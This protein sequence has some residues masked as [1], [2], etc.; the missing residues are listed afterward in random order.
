MSH[1]LIC[2]WLGLPADGWPPDHYNLLGLERGEA[3]RDR[4][5]QHVHEHLE[6]VRRYQ[7]AHPEQV[8]EAMNRLAQAFV[9]LTDPDA[10][11]AYDATLGLAPTAP[12][13]GAAS[14]EPPAKPAAASLLFPSGAAAGE[15]VDPLAWL[16][17]PWNPAAA[18]PAAPAAGAPALV[19]WASAPPPPRL[20]PEP[21]TRGDPAAAGDGTATVRESTVETAVEHSPLPAEPSPPAEEAAPLGARRGLGTK[22]ALYY[23]ISR[24]R[25]LL[26][27]W[28]QAGRYLH[29]PT[30]L[31]TRPAE[32]TELIRLLQSVRRLLRTF[33]PL[34]GEAGQPG[35][36]VL[37]L[38]RQQLIVPTFQ[39]L[40]PSQREALARDWQAGHGLLLSHREFL[41]QELRGLRGRGRLGRAFRAL[42]LTLRDHPGIWLFLLGLLALN[43]SSDSVKRRWPEQVVGLAVAVALY[44]LLWWDAHR[45]AKPVR[46]TPPPLPR[47]ARSRPKTQRQAP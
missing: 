11:R 20:Q 8:T 21:G 22:R 17:G 33:P 16:F 32:A 29:H 46:T 37:A 24:T 3:N 5:E 9:C 42:R 15:T 13:A 4:I 14:S 28:E 12:A 47:S 2:T 10:K 36:L 40:L 35:Y 45:P 6:R 39:T 44:F 43:L 27:S 30:R 25:Q 38:A 41:R 1:E 7:L 18:Q 26:W 31:L 23:R 34:L 19:D